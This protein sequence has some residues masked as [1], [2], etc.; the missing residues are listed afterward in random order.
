MPA[1][2]IAHQRVWTSGA[3]R[4]AP[5]G[6]TDR[7]AASVAPEGPDCSVMTDAQ[8]TAMLHSQMPRTELV[9]RTT[10]TQAVIEP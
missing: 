8:L 5:V 10:Q 2:R 9:A 3:R 1:G 4:A 7:A 6:P